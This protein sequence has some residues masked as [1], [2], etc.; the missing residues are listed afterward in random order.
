VTYNY[1]S[2]SYPEADVR[3]LLKPIQVE[4]TPIAEKEQLIQSGQKH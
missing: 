1:F 2:G 4:N 3:F